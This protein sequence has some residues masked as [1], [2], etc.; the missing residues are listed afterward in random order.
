MSAALEPDDIVL[1]GGNSK[2]LKELPP[3]CR[4]GDNSHAFIGG[5]RLWDDHKDKSTAA[6]KS[7]H[8]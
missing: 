2:K 6:H 1:G 3:H 5:F 8:R 7:A 4:L